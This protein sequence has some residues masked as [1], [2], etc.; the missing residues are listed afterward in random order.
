MDS[1]EVRNIQLAWSF[2]LGKIQIMHEWNIHI[3][4]PSVQFDKMELLELTERD[5]VGSL[6]HYVQ[7]FN[8]KLTLIPF[9]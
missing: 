1:L 5:G 6:A 9:K 7:K 3:T 8:A 2:D 4:P